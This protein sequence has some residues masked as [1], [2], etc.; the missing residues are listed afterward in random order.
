MTRV[1]CKTT[2]IGG[3]Y[4]FSLSDVCV[5]EVRALTRGFGTQTNAQLRRA[6]VALQARRFA[7]RLRGERRAGA[8]FDAVDFGFR[9][10]NVR[11]RA[12]RARRGALG[13]GGAKL[14]RIWKSL[15][16]RGGGGHQRGATAVAGR[17][18]VE[19]KPELSAVMALRAFCAD[20]GRRSAEASAR[21]RRFGA[22]RRRPVAELA[23]GNARAH[24]GSVV[25]QGCTVARLRFLETKIAEIRSAQVAGLR[26]GGRRR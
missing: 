21:Q 24:L 19:A 9:N 7:E 17:G 15:G 5:P 14:L 18:D 12:D 26:D 2:K 4:S 6:V 13:R 3:S 22:K 8:G 25:R 11:V 23:R 20:A 1:V 10:A 16:G